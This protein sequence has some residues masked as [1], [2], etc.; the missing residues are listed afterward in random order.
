[1]KKSH[2]GDSPEPAGRQGPLY[3][4]QKN[5]CYFAQIAAGLEPLAQQE[6]KRLGAKKIQPGFR[7]L[8]FTAEK[9]TLYRV[10]YQSRLIQ[11][12]IAPLELLDCHSTKYLYKR[13]KAIDWTDFLSLTRTFAIVSNVS[14]SHI[15]HSKYAALCLKDAIVDFFTESVGKRPNVDTK[16]PDVWLNLYIH[17]NRAVIGLE[18]SGGS[19]H[20]RGYRVV[21]HEAPIQETVAAAMLELAEWNGERPLYDPMCGSGTLLCEAVMRY[22]R[23]PAGY[24]RRQFGF[25][26]LP[27]FDPALWQSVKAEAD[28][29]IRP[30]PPDLVA[31]S[32]IS[33][34]ALEAAT[35]N[36]AQLPQGADVKLKA[37]DFRNIKAL[38]NTVIISNPPH[39]LRL[40]KTEGMEAF[41]KDL[42]D[43]LK[44]HCQG[45]TAYLYFGDR[46]WIKHIGL[47]TTWKKPLASGGLDG[48]L[49]KLEIF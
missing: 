44:Q 20:K 13:A 37:I 11:K 12:I 4:Y 3:A 22:C 48:R 23:I 5:N 8:Y 26:A 36:L 17:N 7:G 24:F 19:L 31:G 28:S 25:E 15:R 47:R 21:G 40:Q 42:G 2:S 27:D 14:N 35:A 33:V 41:C 9:E 10:N 1:M 18:V 39:G 45:S 46:T 32:D 29:Q 34:K 38:E 49:I 43:F 16:D 6:L 30:L